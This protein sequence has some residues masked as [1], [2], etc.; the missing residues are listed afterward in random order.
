[1]AW[2]SV[3]CIFESLRRQIGIRLAGNQPVY[4]HHS[5]QYCLWPARCHRC[6]GRGTSRPKPPLPTTLFSSARLCHTGRR[7]G[8]NLE[9]RP[10]TARAAI[11]RALDWDPRI[12]ILDDSTNS[13]DVATEAHIQRARWIRLCR[14]AP[15]L[16]SPNAS[17]RCST[18][19][20]FWSWTKYI[21]RGKHADLLDSNPLYAEI[22]RSQLVEDAAPSTDTAPVLPAAESM[23]VTG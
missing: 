1:M 13:V 9:R 8:R 18:L 10:K 4:W 3:R 23:P 15:A 12:L 6:R 5:R 16:S 22:Y 19:T 21:C 11:A 7:T 17:A 20:K 2:I 14:G